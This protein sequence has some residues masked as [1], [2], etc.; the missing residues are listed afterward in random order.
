[1]S[2]LTPGA[3]TASTPLPLRFSLGRLNLVKY[4]NTPLVVSGSIRVNIYISGPQKVRNMP[5][6]ITPEVGIPLPFDV[7]AQEAEEFR[8]RARAACETIKALIEAGAPMPEVTDGDT[9]A[10]HALFA[11]EK[12][13]NVAKTPPATILKLEALLNAYDYEFL[14]AKQKFTNFVTNRLLEETEDEDA[15]IRLKALEMLGKRRGVNLFSD[16]ME[17]TI[18]QKPTEEIEG[19]LNQ[20]LA[21]YMGEAVLVEAHEIDEIG[22]KNDP[23]SPLEIDLDAELGVEEPE[24]DTPRTDTDE[25]EPAEPTAT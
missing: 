17:I 21:R 15:R 12:P 24:D 5:L 4:R 1:M 8:E 16:Q 6:V 9:F 25:P 10:A 14:D 23:P 22:S 13:I 7:T 20:L 19:R 18:R 11:A 3:R 2:V